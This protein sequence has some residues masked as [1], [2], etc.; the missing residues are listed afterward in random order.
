MMLQD[1]FLLLTSGAE[2]R[3]RVHQNSTNQPEKI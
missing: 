3:E 2:S 1:N